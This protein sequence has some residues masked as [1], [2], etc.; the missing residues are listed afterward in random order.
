[1]TKRKSIIKTITHRFL[2]TSLTLGIIFVA[3]GSIALAGTITVIDA[4]LKSMLY[5]AHERFWIKFD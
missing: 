5:Y 2:S 1:M 3:T 4:I